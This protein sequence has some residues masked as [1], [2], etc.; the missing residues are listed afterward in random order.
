[1]GGVGS[2]VTTRDESGAL[3]VQ[4]T[5][6][7]AFGGMTAEGPPT[8][9]SDTGIDRVAF[10]QGSLARDATFFLN[11]TTVGARDLFQASQ[12]AAPPCP[13]NG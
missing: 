12:G 10:L 3:T 9:M 8:T 1:M 4:G 11:G 7:S 6:S 13:S 5:K 2:Q